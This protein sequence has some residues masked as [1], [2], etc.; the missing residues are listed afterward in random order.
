MHLAETVL[1]GSTVTSIKRIKGDGIGAARLLGAAEALR[2]V[3][4]T[5]MLAIER[6]EYQGEV[7]HLRGILD[8]AAFAQ[9]W[10]DGRSLSIDAAI[11]LALS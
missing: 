5:G 7:S 9:A 11:A 4:G 3:A 10:A 2:E 1:D 8:P 6:A